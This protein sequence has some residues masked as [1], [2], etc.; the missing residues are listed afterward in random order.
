MSMLDPRYVRIAAKS[1]LRG[2]VSLTEM[3][4][5]GSMAKRGVPIADH[6]FDAYCAMMHHVDPAHWYPNE[7]PDKTVRKIFLSGGRAWQERPAALAHI[8]RQDHYLASGGMM[9]MR[10]VS[11]GIN[12]DNTYSISIFPDGVDVVC[13]GLESVDSCLEGHYDRIDDLPNW[14]KER[15]AVLNMIPVSPPTSTVE[16][17]GRRISAHVYW[18]FA[19]TTGNEASTSA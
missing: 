16:G 6:H 5:V 4:I 10:D 1:K 2:Q 3:Q 11:S 8:K 9:L 13:F 17:V 15:I 18:V 7:P 14:V 19:P 12:D